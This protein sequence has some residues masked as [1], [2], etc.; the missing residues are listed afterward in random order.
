[1]TVDQFLYGMSYFI[2]ED[3]LSREYGKSWILRDRETARVLDIGLPWAKANGQRRDTRP[4]CVVGI[5]PGTELQAVAL[6]RLRRQQ[7]MLLP[8][9]VVSLD[10]SLLLPQVMD[11]I[12]VP[13]AQDM[14][15]CDFLAGVFQMISSV[16][17]PDTYGRNWVLRDMTSG[18]VFDV[19]SPWAKMMGCTRDERPLSVVGIVGGAMLQVVAVR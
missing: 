5:T 9:G 8:P 1:M 4:V 2:G 3:S 16:T 12:T 10:I 7:P 6:Q 13:Y 18:R 11:R 19:G 14:Q 17:R 15:S